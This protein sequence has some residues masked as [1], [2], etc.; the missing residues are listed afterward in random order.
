[1]FLFQRIL[2]AIRAWFK[3]EPTSHTA[4]NLDVETLRTIEYIAE[5][6]QR[7]PEDVAN[8]ILED[9]LRNHQAQQENWAK[10]KSLTPR[11]QEVAAL[12]CLNYTSRQ[13]AAKLHIST[14]TVK[15]HAEHILMKF[16][17]SDR[18]ALRGLLGRWDFS[19]W[20]R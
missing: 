11:E 18:N 7:T 15:T 17:V 19:G 5:L 4:F 14:E 8:K 16:D 10:W 2:R 1:M 13:V 9:V 6:E 20:D 3:R 12:I